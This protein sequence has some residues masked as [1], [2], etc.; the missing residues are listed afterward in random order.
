VPDENPPMKD[1]PDNLSLVQEQFRRQAE[2][3]STLNVGAGVG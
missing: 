2:A 3:Y 1:E